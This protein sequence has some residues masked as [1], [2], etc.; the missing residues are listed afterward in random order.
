MSFLIVEDEAVSRLI[1]QR[2]LQNQ[3]YEVLVARDGQ[4]GWEIFQR[5]KK[6]IYLLVIDWMMPVMNGLELCEKIRKVETSH[7]VYIIFLSAKREKKDIVKGLKAGA[8]DYLTKPF[9]EDELLSRISVGLKI[10]KL[11]QAL[12]EANQKLYILATLD[13]LTKILNR[14]ELLNRLKEELSR[15][16]RKRT[17]FY[18]FMLDI[19]HFKKVNDR[20]GHDAG[21]KVLIEIANRIKSRLRSYDVVG[22]YGGEEFLIG[23]SKADKEIVKE[24]AERLRR[25]ICEKPFNINDKSLTVSISIGLAKIEPSRDVDLE[26]AIRKADAALYK[27]KQQGRNRVVY[28]DK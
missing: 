8:D 22:R 6:N 20:Y 18:L 13:G 2:I 9:D 17:P 16:S 4:E 19:D 21:D 23:I 26:A 12:K 10:I 24:I 25:C 14:R 27:A 1:L 15:A 7:Y 3:G 28:I 5:E 11:E